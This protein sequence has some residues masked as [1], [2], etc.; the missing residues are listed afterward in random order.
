VQH[1]INWTVKLVDI[2]KAKSSVLYWRCPGCGRRTPMWVHKTEPYPGEGELF[3][4][5]FCSKR[6][7]VLWELRGGKAA[8][9]QEPS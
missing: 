9:V 4:V 3:I 1:Y 8:P 2:Q 5:D 7:A 6:C